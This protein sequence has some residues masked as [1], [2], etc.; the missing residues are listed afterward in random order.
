MKFTKPSAICAEKNEKNHNSDTNNRFDEVS[1]SMSDQT[2][3]LL[4]WY[5]IPECGYSIRE[6]IWEYSGIFSKSW[7]ER[8]V[9]LTN[10]SDFLPTSKTHKFK[11]W[12]VQ[13]TNYNKNE[14]VWLD[15]SW[16]SLCTTD[17]SGNLILTFSGVFEKDAS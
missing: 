16:I 2:A 11:N 9:G 4:N 1:G 17:A 5:T 13:S 10:T 3:S 7:K 15:E 8:Y 6:K 14:R 12:L